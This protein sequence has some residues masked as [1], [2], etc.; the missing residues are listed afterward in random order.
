M[1]KSIGAQFDQQLYAGALSEREMWNK[2][3]NV[4]TTGTQITTSTFVPLLLQ[5]SDPRLL[6][7]ASGTSSLGGTDNQMIPVN[8]YPAKG[9]PK[10]GIS[11]SAYRS[12][13]TG[14]N[15]LMREWHRILHEDGVKVWSVSPG[16]LATGLGGNQRANKSAG[17]GDPKTAGPIF[18]TIIE[19]E[20]DND[21]GKVIT[22]AGVQSW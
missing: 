15:M 14:L 11:L 1:T 3:W 22:M 19:G 5:S 17:A 7:V 4:N 12:A 16:Y 21:V 20:R 10:S 18:R 8:R 6:F 2:S 13:K 9:W